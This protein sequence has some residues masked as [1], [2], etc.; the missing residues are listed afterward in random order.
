MCV[1]EFVC[2]CGGGVNESKREERGCA[3][4]QRERE[5]ESEGERKK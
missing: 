4:F 2:K 3:C 1:S 5:S